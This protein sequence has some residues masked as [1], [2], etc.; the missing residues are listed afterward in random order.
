MVQDT[1]GVSPLNC[2]GFTPGFRFLR[3]VSCRHSCALHIRPTIHP[4]SREATS[5]RSSK[6][7]YCWQPFQLP[8]VAAV[9]T[10]PNSLRS[11]WYVESPNSR[12]Y[13]RTNTAPSNHTLGDIIHF[14]I[15]NSSIVVLGSVDVIQECL[16]KHSAVTS[17]RQ[18]SHMFEL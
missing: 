15:L 17:S 4:S 9:G 12:R 1:Q 6:A 16:E 13:T 14:Q 11:V 18:Q 3:P 5:S 8:Y 2:Y 7:T 10:I